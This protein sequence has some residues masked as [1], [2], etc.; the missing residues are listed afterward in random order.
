M[1]NLIKTT[2]TYATYANAE[3]ALRR[4]AGNINLDDLRYVITATPDGR[5][6]PAVLTKDEIAVIDHL[7][8]L[9]ARQVVDEKLSANR[10][11]TADWAAI[12]Q[13]EYDRYYRLLRVLT[14]LGEPT[15]IR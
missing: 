3:A 9:R 11:G 14:G 6:A 12:E 7:C 10:T 1:A 4:A 2:R 15:P 13:A 5:F 8:R